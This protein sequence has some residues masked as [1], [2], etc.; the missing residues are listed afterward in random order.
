MS[1]LEA[2]V[3]IELPKRP[4]VNSDGAAGQVLV[5][6]GNPLAVRELVWADMAGGTS[7]PEPT[8]ASFTYNAAGDIIGIT[9]LVGGE[10]RTT[11]LTYN[12]LGDVLTMAVAYQAVTKTTTFSYDGEGNMTGYMV[13]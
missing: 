10:N 11:T 6:S 9:E 1:A 2:F 5:R 3:N 13:V 4:F 8:E 7:A 12:S